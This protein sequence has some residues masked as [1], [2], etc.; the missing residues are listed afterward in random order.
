[1]KQIKEDESE[2][3]APKNRNISAKVISPKRK[4]GLPRMG[5]SLQDQRPHTYEKS[6][7]AKKTINLGYYQE[8]IVDENS[9]NNE[10]GI[11]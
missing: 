6:Y 9:N 4:F 10:P 5:L 7:T 3:L 1:M 8:I 2:F 11:T